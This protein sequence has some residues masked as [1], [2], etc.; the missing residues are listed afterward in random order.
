MMATLAD[1]DLSEI[2]SGIGPN[3]LQKI[4]VRYLHVPQ[5]AID[6]YKASSRED[7]EGF[8]FK[9]LEHWRNQNPG[10]DAKKK[11][12]DL[13]EQARKEE[14]LINILC[15]RFLVQDLGFGDNGKATFEK[16][17]DA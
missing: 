4:A 10:P 13:L 14:G 2:G 7:I 5:P 11:L 15:Y 6:T 16:K 3:D 17:I 9:L 1:S 12:F 8:K